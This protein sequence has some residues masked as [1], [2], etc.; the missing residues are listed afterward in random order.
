M[1]ILRRMR[2][3]RALFGA[4]TGGVT[5]AIAASFALLAV[6]SVVA[7]RGW[8]ESNTAP[9]DPEV[10]QLRKVRAQVATASAEVQAVALPRVV[11]AAPAKRHHAAKKTRH[12][13][14]GAHAK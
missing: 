7:F 5:L 13:A 10:T 6:S 12:R 2:S 1:P 8:P 4:F 9:K 3:T 14:A 11:A